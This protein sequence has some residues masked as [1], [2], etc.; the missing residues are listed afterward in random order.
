MIWAPTSL[1][2]CNQAWVV[3]SATCIPK[4]YLQ[5]SHSGKNL[6]ALDNPVSPVFGLVPT[7]VALLAIPHITL[8]IYLL[9]A[10]ISAA[11]RIRNIVLLNLC[12][13][14][15][16]GEVFRIIMHAQ[17][18]VFDLLDCLELVAAETSTS[19]VTTST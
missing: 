12:D 1:K 10:P 15:A 11:C 5:E 2:P 7:L 14:P 19:S 6:H 18:L 9:V 4:R 17:L 3:Q 13:N 8:E 16:N